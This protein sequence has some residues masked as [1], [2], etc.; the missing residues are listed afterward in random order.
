MVSSQELN[1][2]MERLKNDA[3][4]VEGISPH[5]WGLNDYLKQLLKDDNL[6]NDA[7]IGSAKKAV[8]AGIHSLSDA[9]L[10]ALALDMLNNEVYMAECPNEWCGERI[11]WGD[12][13][14]ALW[15]GQCYHCV[16]RQEKI[17]RE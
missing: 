14:S 10:K 8:S 4:D 15:E 16:N 2:L 5:S 7:A 11:A 3:S 13:N 6:V 1:S 9:Q 17:D 12:M